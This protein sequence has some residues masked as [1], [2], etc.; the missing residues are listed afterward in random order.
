MCWNVF[1]PQISYQPA[2]Y[3]L[4]KEWMNYVVRRLLLF[5]SLNATSFSVKYNLLGGR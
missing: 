5:R 2:E 1:S 3:Q 4:V